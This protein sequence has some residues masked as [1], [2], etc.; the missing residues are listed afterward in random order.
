MEFVCLFVLL[1][2]VDMCLS[3]GLIPVQAGIRNVCTI[4]SVRII[5]NEN[6]I[7]CNGGVGG[8]INAIHWIYKVIYKS[9]YKIRIED[10]A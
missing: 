2:Y 1:A 3:T 10:V 8:R 9:G 4:H 5:S 6:T 7:R